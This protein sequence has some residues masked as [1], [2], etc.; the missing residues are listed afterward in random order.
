M[1]IFG[2]KQIRYFQAKLEEG[3]GLK[4]LKNEVQSIAKLQHRNLVKLGGCCIHW[5]EMTL[6]YEYLPNK[7]LDLFTFWF[8]SLKPL[9]G[10]FIYLSSFC[11]FVFFFCSPF[12]YKC[13][14][15]S[16]F[17]M[18]LT[19]PKEKLLEAR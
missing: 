2:I 1:E 19:D 4:E 18:D 15:N 3:Q 10:F 11:I 17:I 9:F 13:Y 6:I 16:L 12:Q 14:E 5:K 8:G 7:S